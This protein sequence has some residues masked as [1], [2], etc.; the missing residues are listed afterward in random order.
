MIIRHVTKIVA[1]IYDAE[2]RNAVGPRVRA[3]AHKPPRDRIFL[4]KWKILLRPPPPH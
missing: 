1:G 2:E 3:A 4:W